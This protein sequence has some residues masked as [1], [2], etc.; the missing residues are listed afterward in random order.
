MI[1][2]ISLAIYYI[3]RLILFL[4]PGF[5]K[6]KE[7]FSK[8]IYFF[9]NWCYNLFLI[10]AES[11]WF[12]NLILFESKLYRYYIYPNQ[13]WISLQES[14]KIAPQ[15]YMCLT[16]GETSLFTI[17]KSLKIVG[18]KKN[19]VFYDLGCGIGRTV[20]FTN[21]TYG[22]KSVGIDMIPTFIEYANKII[23]ETGLTNIKF[24]NDSIFNQ[25]INEGTI[26]YISSTC[27]DNEYMEK[28]IDK[29]KGINKGS[30]VISISRPINAPNLRLITSKNMFYSW[31][32]DK[33][34]FQI[35]V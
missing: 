16:Y 6:P 11:I 28:L 25:D 20:F 34:Y 2:L 29:L 24:I 32:I 21:I 8:M 22:I 31:G 7:F 4:R 10:T 14:I 33:T 19:D 26:F 9:C 18:I 1:R 23:K 35:A 17:K 12:I 15:K 27:Y 3:Q 30:R 5:F 13:F